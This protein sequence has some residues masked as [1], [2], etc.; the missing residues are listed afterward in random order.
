VSTFLHAST[1]ASNRQFRS[2]SEDVGITEIGEAS[3]ALKELFSVEP[4]YY[5]QEEHMQVLCGKLRK[6]SLTSSFLIVM[7]THYFRL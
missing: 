4:K 6:R 5:A 1:S 3:L 2:E 7:S